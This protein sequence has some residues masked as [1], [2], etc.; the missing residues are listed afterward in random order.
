M[1][2]LNS[3]GISDGKAM[4]ASQILQIVEALNGT[5][6]YD[7]EI[8]GDTTISPLLSSEGINVLTIDNSGK[9]FKTGSYVSSQNQNPGGSNTQVQYNNEGIFEGN[10]NFT[11]DPS[12]NT[13]NVTNIEVQN[14]IIGTS[15]FSINSISS[16]YA[17]SC[18]YSPTNEDVLETIQTLTDRISVLE[19]QVNGGM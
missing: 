11:F 16:S 12:S 2:K 18:S 4:Q 19:S 9:I 3:T 1:A 5:T 6:S 17:L 10:L 8:K 14:Q 7:I 13:L 15:S